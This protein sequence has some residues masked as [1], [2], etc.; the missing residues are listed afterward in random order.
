MLVVAKQ[1][2]NLV[3]NGRPL[4][5]YT[6]DEIAKYV[7]CRP[8]TVRNYAYNGKD[9]QG[10]YKFSVI[11]EKNDSYQVRKL[12]EDWDEIRKEILDSGYDLSRIP[13]TRKED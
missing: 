5:T 9:Y 3:E 11:Q 1:K 4:G 10:M 12:L 2:Y 13:V 6:A 7:G 8:Q